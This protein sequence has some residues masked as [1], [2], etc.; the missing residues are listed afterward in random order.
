MAGESTFSPGTTHI[1]LPKAKPIRLG[2][3][4]KELDKLWTEFE[5]IRK[6]GF[7]AGEANKTFPRFSPDFLLHGLKGKLSR[8]SGIW[9]FSPPGISIVSKICNIG[10]VSSDLEFEGQDPSTT[11]D[12]ETPGCADFW[13]PDKKMSSITEAIMDLRTK[14]YTGDGYITTVDDSNES[15][16]IMFAFDSSHLELEP[17][18]RLSMR[19]TQLPEELW[20]NQFGDR[21]QFPLKTPGLQIAIPFGLPA[22]YIEYV[23]VNE[24]SPYWQGEKLT[25]LQDALICDNHQIPMISINNNGILKP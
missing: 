16:T 17:L 8:S 1:E 24:Q 19:D 4:G 7:Y 10:V 13:I 20:A 22:N 18:F 3:Y 12:E 15:S 14:V 9:T 25:K 6:N 11:V 21:I 23:V 5:R 2:E